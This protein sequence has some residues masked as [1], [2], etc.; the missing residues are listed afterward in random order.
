MEKLTGG[1]RRHGIVYSL[2]TRRLM[3]GPFDWSAHLEALVS[4]YSDE[5]NLQIPQ[6]MKKQLVTSL[7]KA[8]FRKIMRVAV[9]QFF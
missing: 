8:P 3:G 9:S 5:Y 4:R 6:P 2:D 7:Y 1:L